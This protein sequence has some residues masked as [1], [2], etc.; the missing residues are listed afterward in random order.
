MNPLWTITRRLGRQ[1][2]FASVG[3][4]LVAVD[5]A[6]QRMTGG[7]VAFGR[8][9][10][11]NPVLLT[12][13]GRV[14]GRQRT[15]PLV[16]VPDGDGFLLVGSNWGKPGHPAWSANLMVHPQATMEI[17][18]HLFPVTATL[19]TGEDRD[20]AWHKAV[21]AWPAYTDY[22]GRADREIRLFRVTR[23]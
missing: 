10:G 6:L 16:A 11:L 19:L 2:W 9:A 13:T 17:R 21:E 23:S 7:L 14:T 18:G 12:T 15:T 8:L 3:S 1:R 4:Q 20:R 22:A 5:R